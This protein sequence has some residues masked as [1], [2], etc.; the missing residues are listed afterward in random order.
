[1]LQSY[2]NI[3]VTLIKDGGENYNDI[4]DRLSPHLDIRQIGYKENKG[5]A[6]ARNYGID[7][8][9][10]EFIVFLDSDDV[11]SNT[12]ALRVLLDKMETEKAVIGIGGF[13]EE[14]DPFGVIPHTKDSSFIHGKMYRRSFLEKYNIRFNE[15]TRCNEDVG[16]N[17]LCLMLQGDDT[18]ITTEFIVSYWLRNPDSIV[19]KNRIEYEDRDSFLGYVD[20]MIYVFNELKKR[21]VNNQKVLQ[22]KIT[23]MERLYILYKQRL[24]RSP[25]FKDINLQ[26]CKK[27]YNEVYKDLNVNYRLLETSYNI[28]K[29]EIGLN[30]IKLFI[31]SLGE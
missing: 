23:T 24:E 29:P 7:Q 12:F 8:T 10:G 16:F 6:Y 5:V 25:Q 9:N 15:Q 27:Y 11:L 26:A 19:R 28:L 2:K 30:E 18:I 13:L 1:M 17:T 14:T 3:T 31:K 4:I 21:N 20:N 22:D